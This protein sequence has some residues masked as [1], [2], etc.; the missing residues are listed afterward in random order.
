M[1]NPT[2]Y[3]HIF[4]SMEIVLYNKDGD[5]LSF[6][7]YYSYTNLNINTQN[8][9]LSAFWDTCVKVF[10]SVCSY[11]NLRNQNFILLDEGGS[12]AEGARKMK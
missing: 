1:N 11:Q 2:K 4:P 7:F 9:N 6:L 3:D 12:R 10:L 8:V 5:K